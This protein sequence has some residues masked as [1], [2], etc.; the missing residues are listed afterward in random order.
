M[1]A[2]I[3]HQDGVDYD[4]ANGQLIPDDGLS[5]LVTLLLFTDARATDTDELPN[6]TPDRKGWPGSTYAGFEWGSR[7]WLLE[8]EKITPSVLHKIKNYSV[9]ALK[10]LI[11]RRLAK[12]VQITVQRSGGTLVTMHIVITKPNNEQISYSTTLRWQ[13]QASRIQTQSSAI[14]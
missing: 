14:F 8:R 2:F 7:L 10:P 6:G 1:L 3:W 9:E 12:D 11:D 13:A 5:T 4:V